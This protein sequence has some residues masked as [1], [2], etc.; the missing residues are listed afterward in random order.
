MNLL[1]YA[2]GFWY[3]FSQQEEQVQVCV[4]TRNQIQGMSG[5]VWIPG[6]RIDTFQVE[7]GIPAPESRELFQHTFASRVEAIYACLLG[8]AH[9]EVGIPFKQVIPLM[10]QRTFQVGG[11]YRIQDSSIQGK[12][13]EHTQGWCLRTIEGEDIPLEENEIAMLVPA[14]SRL[15]Y[16]ELQEKLRN[17]N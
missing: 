17:G 8:A 6:K 12:L 1:V 14:Q 15:R 4:E 3:T 16:S 5:E 13:M 10:E 9:V 7:E 11:N 2:Q